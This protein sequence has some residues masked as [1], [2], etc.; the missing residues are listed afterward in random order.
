MTVND[1][2]SQLK[3]ANPAEYGQ[4]R[5]EVVLR[6]LALELVHE[7]LHLPTR[8]F[9]EPRHAKSADRDF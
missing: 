9:D 2:L 1:Y 7:T 3:T 8:L 6:I 4:V 5:E